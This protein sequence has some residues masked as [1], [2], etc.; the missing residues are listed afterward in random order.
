M[1]CISSTTSNGKN[2]YGNEQSTKTLLHHASL[3]SAGGFA[4]AAIVREHVVLGTGTGDFCMIDGVR[5]A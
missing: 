5:K 3:L 1:E 2:A 4:R